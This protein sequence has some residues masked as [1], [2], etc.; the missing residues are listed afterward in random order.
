MGR[1]GKQKR[2][3]VGRSTGYAAGGDGRPRPTTV[4]NDNG[5]LPVFIESLAKDAG[6]RI[7]RASRG[8]AHD[9]FY[10]AVGKFLRRSILGEDQQGEYPQHC[11]YGDAYRHHLSRF[12]NATA[13]LY[14]DNSSAVKNFLVMYGLYT[15]TTLKGP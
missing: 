12:K 9:D 8:I 6:V 13:S 4:L 5:V 3:T 11:I 7:Y 14:V 15:K 1:R 10:R 2:I